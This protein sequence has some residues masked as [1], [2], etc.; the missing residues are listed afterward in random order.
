MLTI[1]WKQ[2]LRISSDLGVTQNPKITH[3]SFTN[4]H[5]REMPTW[6]GSFAMER[7]FTVDLATFKSAASTSPRDVPTLIFI[8]LDIGGH[9][10]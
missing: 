4:G 6:R 10:A 8:S 1:C 3:S 5:K 2:L 9:V 7:V